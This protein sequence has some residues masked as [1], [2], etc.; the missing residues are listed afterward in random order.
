MVVLFLPQPNDIDFGLDFLGFDRHMDSL[1]F[2]Q[3]LDSLVIDQHVIGSLMLGKFLL[4]HLIDGQ[5]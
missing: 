4:H 5:G 1:V 2:D 3:H